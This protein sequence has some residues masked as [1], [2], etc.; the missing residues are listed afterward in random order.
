MLIR[1]SVPTGEVATIDQLR[2]EVR[3]QDMTDDD[4]L[5]ADILAAQT[6]RYEDFT[7][8][9]MLPVAMEARFDGGCGILRL[10]ACPIRDITGIVCL[11]A[12]GNEVALTDSDQWVIL[13]GDADWTVLMMTD[14]GLPDSGDQLQPLR[15]RFIAGHLNSEEAGESGHPARLAPDPA[16]RRHILAMVRWAYDKDEQMPEDLMR[17]AMGHRR[18]IR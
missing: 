13:D 16:D 5:L 4:A 1:T 10:P 12:D 6:R 18:V 8:R 15:V 7:G 2:A 14:A 17:K 3:A 9:T 11:D